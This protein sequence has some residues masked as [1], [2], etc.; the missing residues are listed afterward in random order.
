MDPLLFLS[1]HYRNSSSS[2]GGGGGPDPSAPADISLAGVLLAAAP[3]LLIGAISMRLRLGLHAKLA[4]GALRCIG[5]L[6]ALGFLLVPIFVANKWWVTATY[7]T[8]MCLVA[9]AE[10]VSRPARAYA[11]MLPQVLAAMGVACAAVITFGLAAVVRAS[12]WYDAQYMIPMLGMLLG[13]ACSA[14][15]VGLSS[16]LDDLSGRR[17]QVEALLALGAS[18]V[19]ATQEVVR[20]AARL[21][22]TPLLNSLNVVGIVSIPASLSEHRR[23]GALPFGV[24]LRCSPETTRCAGAEARCPIWLQ[25]MMT[26]QILGGS[27]PS[28]AARYQIVI[29]FLVSTSTGLSAFATI[30][31][32][33]LSVCDSSHRLRVDWL[34]PRGSAGSG[35]AGWAVVQV[36]EGWARARAG[37]SRIAARVRRAARGGQPLGR[38]R[39]HYFSFRSPEGVG[40]GGRAPETPS[41]RNVV[42]EVPANGAGMA[43]VG[44]RRPLLQDDEPASGHFT[45]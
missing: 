30:Y 38:G 29:F 9:S 19:E 13:N 23:D 8:A 20:K 6:S 1:R 11:G 43:A 12:P 16:A 44:V 31:A 39:H 36:A 37:A 7:A 32:A 42:V 3:L 25:G 15:A 45:P 33:V 24:V 21:A 2:S 27:D 18:R 14:V 5:Q 10:A 4:V 28:V 34:T 35:A 40:A 26:G 41:L 17:E 22:L